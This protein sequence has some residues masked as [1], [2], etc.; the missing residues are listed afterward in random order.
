[1]PGNPGEAR[2]VQRGCLWRMMRAGVHLRAGNALDHANAR[3]T[4]EATKRVVHANA[5]LSD[6]ITFQSLQA[7][8][9]RHSQAVS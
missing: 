8:A 5:L 2:D 4:G 6:S 9:R 3:Q 7:I 1:M